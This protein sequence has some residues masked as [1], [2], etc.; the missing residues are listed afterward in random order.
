MQ[1]QGSRRAQELGHTG[2]SACGIFHRDQT[3]LSCIGRQITTGPPEVPTLEI[4]LLTVLE[5]VVQEHV[6]S[7]LVSS[8]GHVE[9]SISLT[10]PS[11]Q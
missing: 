7:G 6:V 5:V 4:Y 3:N 9:N 11:F 2:C 10:L 1:L 8:E